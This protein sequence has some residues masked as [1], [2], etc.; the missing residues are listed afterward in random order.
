MEN[1]LDINIDELKQ[2]VIKTRHEHPKNWV[3]MIKRRY[4]YI[5]ELAK[6]HDKKYNLDVKNNSQLFYNWCYD[7]KNIP[8]CEVT[9]KQL[10]FKN[11]GWEYRKVG[12]KGV[13]T[14]EMQ[15]QKTKT[16]CNNDK[17]RKIEGKSYS[18]NK[19]ISFIPLNDKNPHE[20]KDIITKILQDCNYN[21]G[22][23]LV[24]IANRNP[25]IIGSLKTHYD[26]LIEGFYCVVH[27]IKERPFCEY[28][29][30]P[31][32]F[33]GPKHGYKKYHPSA[34]ID[35]KRNNIKN[36]DVK[37]N[38]IDSVYD[39]ETTKRL[40][41]KFISNLSSLQNIKQCLYKTEENYK[42]IKSIYDY[43]KHLNTKKFSEKCFYL[44]NGHPEIENGKF[45]FNSFIKGYNIS[46]I[47]NNRSGGELELLSFLK[48]NNI[49]NIITNSRPIEKKEL[50]IFLP[51]Y[52]IGIEF[53]GLYYHSNKF[54]HK[55]THLHKK[56]LCDNKNIK[57]IQIFENEWH[58]KK[59]I[60]KSIILSKL[61]IFQFRIYARKC[62]IK[63]V[64][65]KER[66]SFLKENHLQGE[67]KS[68][69]AFGLYYNNCLISLIT[70]GKRKITG[71]CTFELIR[72]CN[73]LNTQVV[74]GFSKLLSYAHK[75]LNINKLITYCDLRY[76]DG[77]IYKIN[78]FIL[79]HISPPNYWYFKPGEP[80]YV[81]LYHRY[82]FTKHTLKNKLQIYNHDLTEK[83]NMENNGF[84]WIYDCGNYVFERDFI[85][86]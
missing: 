58:Q 26:N 57:L 24:K 13:F 9:K 28:T 59:S 77:N 82:N 69:H 70:L 71:S 31:T 1:R 48:E 30:K 11:N 52:N 73:K 64:E 56:N 29:K 2:L 66:R 43:T 18:L 72:F 39:I 60:V 83:Q 23:L 15:N 19:K 75:K 20:Y 80:Q 61:N 7:I 84:F 67:D 16:R 53:H 4:L 36:I 6:Q 35:V 79:S 8:C 65:S 34:V 14:K 41:R 37:I 47:D 44:L 40:L 21:Y 27:S 3:V 5:Y 51:D 12:G 33:L 86:N 10:N 17:K 42:L 38:N 55:N 63:P 25:E 81:R 68:Q 49:K 50:D 62:E 85:S 32:P 78:K 76:S 46:C 54:I 74:G 22:G 45:K